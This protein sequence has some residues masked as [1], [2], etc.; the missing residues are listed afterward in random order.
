MI[1][2]PELLGD[3]RVLFSSLTRDENGDAAQI[4]LASPA[5]SERRSL[6]FGGSQPRYLASGHLVF[7][8]Q[9]Q[10]VAVAFDANKQEVRGRVALVDGIAIASGTA[11]AQFAVS[12]SGTLVYLD[13]LASLSRRLVWVDRDGNTS[14]AQAGSRA[15]SDI[16]F[17][18][19]GRRV[20]VHDHGAGN[21]IWIYS[22]ERGTATRMSYSPLADEV[23]VWSPDGRFVVYTTDNGMGRVLKRAPSD[24]SGSE[25]ALWETDRHTHVADWTPDGKALVLNLVRPGTR[26]DT[27][28]LSLE[29]EPSLQPL[30]ESPFDERNPR[31]APGGKWIAYESD[32]SG[33][34]EI[35]VTSFPVPG[36]KHVLSTGGGTQVVWS[37][38][39]RELFYRSSTHLMAVKVESASE[40]R[41]ETP[42]ALFSDPFDRSGGAN[43]TSYDVAH[44]GRFLFVERERGALDDAYGGLYRFQVVIDWVAELEER[45]PSF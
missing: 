32:E 16:R 27:L 6:N 18:P 40:F 35:Y 4:I 8:D 15:Y 33:Q 23:P 37:A 1:A 10:L 13:Y 41:F 43:H 2:Y 17:S 31:L 28:L 44:D 30:L 12:D 20:A 34:H 36:A 25:E 29:G 7:A 19:D 42:V 24:G 39:G 11:A 26:L 45:V 21:D 22:P 38:D 9:G 5:T 3:G 14:S